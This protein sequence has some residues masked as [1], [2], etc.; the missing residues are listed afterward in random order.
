MDRK[1]RD[2]FTSLKMDSSTIDENTIEVEET[3][4]IEQMD[5]FMVFTDDCTENNID[6]YKLFALIVSIIFSAT[7]KSF[8]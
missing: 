4:A 1:L 2:V 3:E 5:D 7:S 8:N 6:H